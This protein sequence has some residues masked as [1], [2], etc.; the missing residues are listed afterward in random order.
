MPV[1]SGWET[2]AVA[3][4][5]V[6]YGPNLRVSWVRLASYVDQV[7]KGADPATLPV[8]LPA[9]IEL[10]VNRKTANALGLKIPQSVLLR[11]DRV[12]E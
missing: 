6:T 11:A 10:I 9:I 7:L 12:I 2:Y 8:E 3:G 1:V 4:C 5:L